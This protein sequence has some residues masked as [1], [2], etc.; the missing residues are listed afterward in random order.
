MLKPV[1]VMST[2]L[3]A[4]PALAQESDWTYRATLYGWLPALTSS[5]ETR[6]GTIETEASGSDVLSSLDMAF[7]G[8]FA[9]QNGRWGFVGDLLYTNLSNS[10]QTPFALYG[11]A[12]V[13]LK[14]TALSGYALYRVTNDPAVQLDFGAGFRSFKV[15]VVAGLSAGKL[16]AASQTLD[17]SWTDPLIAARLTIPFSD[18]WFLQGFADWGGTGSNDQTYQIYTGIGYKFNDAWSAQLGY[19]YMDISKQINGRNVAL[20]LSG[21]LM[22]VSY[23]F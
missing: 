6:F 13:D 3:I 22:A 8:S 7:M 10:Q 2:C 18:D 23:S 12:S 4:G 17:G 19:R 15:D 20:G 11:D 16:P 21:G 9:A 14:M 1:V 5:V